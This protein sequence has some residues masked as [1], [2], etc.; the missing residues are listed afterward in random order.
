MHFTMVFNYNILV[1]IFIKQIIKSSNLY[2]NIHITYIY[3]NFMLLN[4]LFEV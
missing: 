3:V 4:I 2:N 1:Y